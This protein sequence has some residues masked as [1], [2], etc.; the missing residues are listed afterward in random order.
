M[1]WVAAQSLVR[2]VVV[3]NLVFKCLEEKNHLY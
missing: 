3:V 2:V 1:L